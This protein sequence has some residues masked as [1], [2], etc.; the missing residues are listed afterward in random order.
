MTVH[1]L[2]MCVGIESPEQ[3]R[4]RQQA[5]LEDQ[6]AA[7][8][9]PRLIH[10]TRN[11]PRRADDI[12]DGGSIYWIMKGMIRARQGITAIERVDDR[13]V[14]KRCALVLDKKVV[15]TRPVPMR[16][17]QGWRY[18]P[19]ADAPPDLAVA[20]QTAEMPESM[21]RDLRELGLL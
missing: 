16:P 11:M 2:K 3:L 12:L 17:I 15:E 7:G 10:W 8:K 13:T 19:P 14:Q 21:I 20:D 4:R 18:L 9:R 1:L 6:K 5:R